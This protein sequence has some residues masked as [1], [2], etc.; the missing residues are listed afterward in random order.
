MIFKQLFFIYSGLRQSRWN[1]K[2][3]N[4]NHC[5]RISQRKIGSEFC[6]TRHWRFYLDFSLNIPIVSKLNRTIKVKNLVPAKNQ[7]VLLK[8]HAVDS[9]TNHIFVQSIT[10]KI[11]AVLARSKKEA[12]GYSE[13]MFKIWFIFLLGHSFRKIGQGTNRSPWPPKVF[14]SAFLFLS[15]FSFF[16][17]HE[18]LFLS[19][20]SLFH[21][22]LV[23]LSFSLTLSGYSLNS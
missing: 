3:I 4:N 22:G 9:L 16:H 23:L 1:K 6:S 13:V 8:Q 2:I 17:P 7:K 12:K 10:V 21:Y 5:L 18:Y 20:L 11:F 14:F 19:Y 15:I